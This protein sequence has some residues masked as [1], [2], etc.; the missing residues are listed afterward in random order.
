MSVVAF[1]AHQENRC[2]MPRASMAGIAFMWVFKALRGQHHCAYIPCLREDDPDFMDSF[3]ARVM[4]NLQLHSHTHTSTKGWYVG[5]NDDSSH[6]LTCV[7]LALFL[8][9]THWLCSVSR[10]VPYNQMLQL[11]YPCNNYITSLMDQ[12]RHMRQ[13]CGW[14][15]RPWEPLTLTTHS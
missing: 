11:A 13:R 7:K 8:A 14:R 3:V 9:P 12:G 10:Q 1:S 4:V 15:P 5:T 2:I 6:A